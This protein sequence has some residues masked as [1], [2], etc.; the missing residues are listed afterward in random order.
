MSATVKRSHISGPGERISVV[1][2]S[3]DR[4]GPVVVITANL[5][6]DEC[7]GI[8]TIHE[9]IRALPQQ[10][11]RGTVRLYPSLNPAGLMAGT[12]GFPGDA[13]D[14]NRAFPGTK[15]G[16]GAQRHAHRIWTDIVAA[17]PAALL[18]LH[19]DSGSAIP[20]CIVDRVIRGRDSASVNSRCHA[21]AEATGL[22]VLNEYLPE[23]YR[24]FELDRSLPGALV[25]G[26][27]VPAIT[28]EVGPRRRIDADAVDCCSQAVQGVLGL[29][30]LIDAVAP[31]HRTRA[32]RG[33]WRR[34][35]GPR[36]GRVGMIVPVLRP[37]ESFDRGAE[38]ARVWTLDGSCVERLNALEPGFIV[39]LPELGYAPIG[40]PCAT[41][42]IRE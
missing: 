38:L 21:M 3:A 14:L 31:I 24:R 33:M 20:Y 17:E 15:A 8:G 25:N 16:T 23:R 32:S 1:E 13:L 5:H 26:P 37:G 42:A 11:L 41:I 35:N 36:T 7:T 4:P 19:T 12:R 22:T 2:L 6:G 28:L 9:L 40:T 29:A 27:G 18:D 10:L 39:A 34:E 30:G